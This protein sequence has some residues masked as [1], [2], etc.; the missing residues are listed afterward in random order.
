MQLGSLMLETAKGIIFQDDLFSGA[1]N[2][3]EDINIS[4]FMIETV[5]E[6]VRK[7]VARNMGKYNALPQIFSPLDALLTWTRWRRSQ[8]SNY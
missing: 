4:N 8:S 1:P 3:N 7:E 2:K 6:L 5:K